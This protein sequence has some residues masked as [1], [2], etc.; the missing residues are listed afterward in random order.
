MF[1]E[2]IARIREGRM[3]RRKSELN[4]DIVPFSSS[5]EI[6]RNTRYFRHFKFCRKVRFLPLSRE[7]PLE[8][9]NS[10]SVFDFAEREFSFSRE[11]S[12]ERGKNLT[13][14]QNIK[15]RK[16]RVLREI[17]RLDEKGTI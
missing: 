12:L 10:I 9:D 2:L 6:S 8:K 1:K 15:W 13:F 3:R 5:L 14:R 16:Y 11:N 17:S 4:R 7:F